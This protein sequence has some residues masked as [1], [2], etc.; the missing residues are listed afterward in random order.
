M[1]FQ[2][3]CKQHNPACLM[4]FTCD[5]LCVHGKS[6]RVQEFEDSFYL[7]LK[8]LWCEMRLSSFYQ[9]TALVCLAFVPFGSRRNGWSYVV[10]CC[11]TIHN[12]LRLYWK[13]PFRKYFKHFCFLYR[14]I[15]KYWDEYFISLNRDVIVTWSRD[16]E[17]S[18]NYGFFA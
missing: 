8:V 2:L 9:R 10:S 14:L 12:V 16:P 5:N 6:P 17:S 3:R 1:W 7:Q 13:S 11:Y 15:I 4:Y 18:S